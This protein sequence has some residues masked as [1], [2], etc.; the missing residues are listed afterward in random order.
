MDDDLATTSLS[1]SQDNNGNCFT[2]LPAGWEQ[3]Q[4]L[5]GRPYYIDHTTRTTTWTRPMVEVPEPLPS[6]WEQEQDPTGRIYYISHITR[7]TTWT[8]PV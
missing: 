4:S 3:Q 2:T 1:Q 7:T 8:R 6:G 5:T